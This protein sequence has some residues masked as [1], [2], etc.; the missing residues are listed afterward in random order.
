MLQH[1]ATLCNTL[2]HT[3][4]N[5]WTKAR[6]GAQTH[7]VRGF[8]WIYVPATHCNSLQ[9]NATQCNTH[10][11]KVLLRVLVA[12][13]W[14]TWLHRAATQCNTLQHTATHCHLWTKAHWAHGIEL[15]YVT[16]THCNTLQHTVTHCNAL[17]HTATHIIKTAHCLGSCYWV[18]ICDCNTLQ[19]ATSHCNT[20]QHTAAQWDTLQHSYGQATLSGPGCSEHIDQNASC[21]KQNAAVALEWVMSRV[22]DDASSV[23]YLVDWFSSERVMSKIDYGSRI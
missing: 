9:H 17:Q 7:W 6:L 12:L 22:F 21:R 5:M 19:H 15:T 10:D 3:A 1:A 4:T 2:Q 23:W 13:S 8:E 16:A 18:D 14:D 11:D 20:L